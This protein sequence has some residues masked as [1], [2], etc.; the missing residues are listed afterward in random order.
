M[1]EFGSFAQGTPV[2]YSGSTITPDIIQTLSNYLDGWFAAVEGAYSPA[3]ED[4]N[5]LGYLFAYQLAYIMQKGISDWDSATTYYT[6]DFVKSNGSIYV[7][8]VDTNLNHAVTDNSFWTGMIQN[9]SLTINSLYSSFSIPTGNSMT[10]PYLTIGSGKTL[11]V[12]SSTSLI[13]VT[14]IVANGTLS[15]QGTGIV[16]IL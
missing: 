14:S 4:M 13:G 6:G 16:R 3:I 10:Y 2:R 1:A 8:S 7:S 11:T 15:I 9:G 5:A 12:G